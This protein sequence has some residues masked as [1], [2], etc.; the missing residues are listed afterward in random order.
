MKQAG[1]LIVLV[2]DDHAD[3]RELTRT[4]LERKGCRVFE[5]ANGREAV[6][7]AA[8]TAFGFILMDLEIDNREHSMPAARGVS[9]NPLTSLS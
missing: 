9:Q 6:N 1:G 3:T 5:A 8:R 4:L 2:V 7:I